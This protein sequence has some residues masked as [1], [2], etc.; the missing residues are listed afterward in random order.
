MPMNYSNVEQRLVSNGL[1]G[2]NEQ[3][4]IQIA[5]TFPVLIIL[6]TQTFVVMQLSSLV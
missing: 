1:H 5:S 2:K 3:Q 4:K 6:S